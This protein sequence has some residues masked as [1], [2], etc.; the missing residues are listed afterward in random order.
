VTIYY[1]VCTLHAGYKHTLRISNIY[2][3]ALQRWWLHLAWILR[4]SYFAYLLKLN[5]FL[6]S[7]PLQY[8]VELGLIQSPFSFKFIIN[9][10]YCALWIQLV[11][12]VGG[13]G[14]VSFSV[15]ICGPRS[16]VLV[17]SDIVDNFSQLASIMCLTIELHKHCA[18]VVCCWWL[19]FL[20]SILLA[21]IEIS[22]TFFLCQEWNKW[23]KYLTLDH[24]LHF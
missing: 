10:R 14:L 9:T 12:R 2:C 1:G 8:F 24:F 4:Y 23:K 17:P 7:F 16:T 3:F 11:T 13:S 6:L 15:S 20:S 5:C 18:D 21:P 19:R 22:A